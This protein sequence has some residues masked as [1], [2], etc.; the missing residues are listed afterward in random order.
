MDRIFFSIKLKTNFTLV[1]TAIVVGIITS[2]IAQIF[3]LVAKSTYQ[4]IVHGNLTTFFQITIFSESI[5]FLPIIASIISGIIVCILIKKFKIGRWHGPA[6][7]IYA[8]HQKGGTLDIKKGILSSFAALCSISGGA[9]VGIYGPLVHFGGT[10]GAFLRRRIFMPYIPH[11]IIIGAGVAAAISAGFS[12]PIAGI[13]FAHEVVLRHFSMRAITAIALSS[14]T[15]SFVANEMNLVSPI[16]RFDEIAFNLLSAIPGLLTLGLI[17]AF[18]SIIFMKSLFLSAKISNKLKVDPCLKPLFPAILC[19]ICGM[20]LPEVIGLGSETII[21]IISNINTVYF[22]I[23]ILLFKIL[24]TSLCIGFNLF[25]GILSPALL[26]GTCTGAII[27]HIPFIGIYENLNPIFAIAGM[28]SVASAVIGGPAT[29]IILILELTGSY[30][31]S[32][33]CILP[34]ALCNL[35]TYVSYGSSFFDA[36]LKSRNVPMGHGREL[37]L[38]NDTKIIEYVNKSFLSFNKEITTQSAL[39]KFKENKCTEAYFIDKDNFYIGKLRLV[40]ILNIKNQK[41]IHYFEKDHVILK[42]TN[43]L[44]ESINSLK[45]FVGESIPVIDKNNKII[46][47]ISENDV[48]KA[49]SSIAQIIRNIEKN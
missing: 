32:I 46:G 31:Y 15:A 37:I 35:L 9:S 8:A 26:I 20:F 42:T 14:V 41:A 17:S 21:N 10:V 5:N 19:G 40:D 44:I 1:I 36:Q 16:L 7:T 49:Y 22:L 24:L 6:D 33:A 25:G 30:E 18:V 23:V 12:S 48:L 38:M 29:A 11:D 4:I 45:E 28:A 27:Y 2:I 13:I 39:K 3:A 47:I 43:N 34:I